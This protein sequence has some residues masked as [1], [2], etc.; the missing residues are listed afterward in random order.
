MIA[1]QGHI[2]IFAGIVLAALMLAAGSARADILP[3]ISQKLAD[4]F[5][6]EKKATRMVPEN[7]RPVGCPPIPDI[8]H[9]LHFNEVVIA[10]LCH[11]P[12]TRAAYLTL[13]SQAASY[14]TNYSDYMP[15]VTATYSGSKSA[16][17][18]DGRAI[19]PSLSKSYGITA[20][21]MLYDFG[22]RE[23][24]LESAEQAL[25]AAGYSYDSTLQ[26]MIAT[27]LQ[28]YFSLLTAQN[29]LDVAWES[30]SYAKQSYEAAALRHEIGLAPLA[31]MLQAKGAY[32]QAILATETAA[33]QLS[34]QQAA[35]AL[36][37]GLPADRPITVA[38]M[39]SAA[40]TRDPFTGDVRSLI[41]Q[42]ER[43]RNDLLAS[44]AQLEGAKRS[45]EALKR[46]N[47]ATVS[48][49]T[50]VNQSNDNISILHGEGATRSQS[51][52]LSVSIPIFTGFSQTYNEAASEDQLEAQEDA[53]TKSELG[54]E[55][56]VWNSWHNYETAKQSWKTSQD[57]LASAT[58]LKDV[59]LGRYKEGLGTILDVLNAQSQYT[60]AL[61]S[62]LQTR[63]SLLTTRVDL[64]RAAGVLDLDT[65][66][67]D[68]TADSSVNLPPSP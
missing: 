30:E 62:Y 38:E 24:K 10:A 46:S 11:N 32:S 4:P 15:S 34:Q 48:L 47:L 56:D 53:L 66:H 26:G 59:A 61:Q 3:W 8:G 64:V 13:L 35:L 45:L 12:D 21:M 44:R 54:V 6:V 42:A 39:D 49:T 41:A 36:L 18:V 28:G 57:L 19:T 60:S 27:A 25:V 63:Y 31:D 50:N 1:K 9:L 58:Q 51:V 67:P 43:K 20:G 17:F 29:G 65:M 68:R 2:K 5:A 33:N 23:F 37:M 55:Q 52:G 14:A 16:T 22:Q 40:L 7:L